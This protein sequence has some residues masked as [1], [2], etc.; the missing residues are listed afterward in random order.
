[1]LKTVPT[2]SGKKIAC[3]VF[4]Y[5]SKDGCASRRSLCVCV[6]W[7]RLMSIYTTGGCGTKDAFQALVKCIDPIEACVCHIETIA[8]VNSF[9]CGTEINLFNYMQAVLDV[10]KRVWESIPNKSERNF[11][12]GHVKELVQDGFVNG[13]TWA[14]SARLTR[15]WRQGGWTNNNCVSF[16][17]NGSDFKCETGGGLI[18]TQAFGRLETKEESE[19]FEENVSAFAIS[20][21]D[22][23][24]HNRVWEVPGLQL[25]GFYSSET[26][27][28][29]W[30]NIMQY[31]GITDT[32]SMIGYFN[33]TQ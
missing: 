12:V 6:E 24:G 26:M 30:S 31:N 33:G 1:M 32:H 25:H 7:F 15:M 18:C 27:C 2:P 28:R 4:W 10:A 13:R 11:E 20:A 3:N 8:D 19:K 21:L 23:T 16:G 14:K 22:H 9:E 29:T 17:H 5:V